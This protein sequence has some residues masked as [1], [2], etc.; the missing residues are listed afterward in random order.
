MINSLFGNSFLL[1]KHILRRE[2]VISI[3]WVVILAFVVVGLV[4][5]MESAIDLESRTAILSVLEMPAMIGMMGPAYAAVGNNFGALYT[6]LML[7]FSAFTV[8]LM[9]IFLVVRHTRADEERGRYEVVRSLPTGRL[10][11]LNA[12]M[13]VS[14]IVNIVLALVIGFGMFVFGDESMGL[15]GSLLWGACLG[16]TGLVFAALAALFSQLSSSSRGATGYSFAVLF[17]L[18]LLRAPGDLNGDMEILALISPLGLGL[19]AQAYIGNYWWPVFVMLGVAV[20]VA[21]IAYRLCLSRDIDQGLIPARAGRADGS[22]LMGSPFGL[23]FKLLRTS[24]IVW[25][26]GMFILAASYATVLEGIDDFIAQNEMYQMLI[27]G[28]AG[29]ELIEG[30]SPEQTV[31]AMRATVGAAGFTMAELF[32]SMVNSMMGLVSVVPLLMF[33]LKARSEEKDARTELVLAAPVSRNKSLVGYA[34][35]AFVSAV[36]IQFLLALGMFS[37]AVSVLPDVS[38]LSLG[39]LL[40]ANMVFVPALWVMV[41]VA[42]FLIGLL[43]KATGAIW[44][45]FAYSFVIIF[46]GRMDIFPSWLGKLTPVGYVPQLPMDEVNGLTLCILTVIAVCLTVLGFVFYNR[47]DVNAI[48][49]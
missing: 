10:A 38:E 21:A 13:I 22:V 18:Y 19:R 46:F 6:N 26:A 48:T 42:I 43:P 15:A 7:L 32:S 45:Y 5:G 40:R 29:I 1:T 4:P 30:L 41:G 28:P 39:F 31:A 12:A 2:R 9:N 44:G 8:G 24:L 17:L 37:V 11:N 23:S 16:A 25:F 3:V 35:I 34:V 27:L 33:I 36:L 20:V 47:R 49:H 14:V